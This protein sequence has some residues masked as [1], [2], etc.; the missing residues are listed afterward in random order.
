MSLADCLQLWLQHLYFLLEVL[1]LGRKLVELSGLLFFLSF[2]T[3][4]FFFTLRFS[5][6]PWSRFSGRSMTWHV[7][8]CLFGRR[9]ISFDNFGRR[10]I[11][12]GSFGRW[13][14]FG[15]DHTT[16]IVHFRDYILFCKPKGRIDT[17]SSF[18][19]QVIVA[20]ISTIE[21]IVSF[22][23]LCKLQVVL[24]LRLSQFFNLHSL[25]FLLRY[26]SLFQLCW[27]HPARGG[28]CR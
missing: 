18:L 17:P 6:S 26:T 14:L 25:Y 8:S 22:E 27:K 24:I 15:N 16:G 1:I 7:S 12:F 9:V 4:S 23:P 21:V 13:F 5:C 3:A 2:G 28:N 11:S 20:P 19:S 10:I